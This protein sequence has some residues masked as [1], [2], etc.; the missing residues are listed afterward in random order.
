MVNRVGYGTDK[1]AL[2]D[3]MYPLEIMDRSL[4]MADWSELERQSAQRTLAL[5]ERTRQLRQIAKLKN[6]EGTK[7]KASEDS[8][9][10]DKTVERSAP[11]RPE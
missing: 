8:S 5:R 6:P 4:D 2:A 3:E 11:S 7:T 9:E 10:L 1:D